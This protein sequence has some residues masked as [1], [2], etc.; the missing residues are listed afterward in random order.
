MGTDKKLSHELL[1]MNFFS[2]LG[3]SEH[4]GFEQ[5]ET[6]V[7][8]GVPYTYDKNNGITV[9]YDEE[10]RPWIKLTQDVGEELYILGIRY[11]FENKGAYVPHSNDGGT[12]AREVMARVMVRVRVRD[13]IVVKV[14]IIP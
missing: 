9:I 3:T 2:A 14:L 4:K 12:F 13:R 8:R 10:G 6:H 1:D 7:E 5:K 11:P